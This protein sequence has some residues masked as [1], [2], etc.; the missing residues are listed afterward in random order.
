MLQRCPSWGEGEDG[1]AAG[2]IINHRDLQL[3]ALR[4]SRVHVDPLNPVVCVS[5]VAMFGPFMED[6]DEPSDGVNM[7]ALGSTVG[8][9][10]A[11]FMD[12]PYTGPS[13]VHKEEASQIIINQLGVRIAY[14]AFKRTLNARSTKSE[15]SSLIAQLSELLGGVQRTFF[16]ALLLPVLRT[17]GAYVAGRVTSGRFRCYAVPQRRRALSGRPSSA[18][19]GRAGTPRSTS[20]EFTGVATLDAPAIAFVPVTL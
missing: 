1:T 17:R 20:G 6:D 18:R 10:V 12:S 7:G 4:V 15:E 8:T 16:A 11:A 19:D 13:V 2:S 14:G 9:L 3:D 5:P